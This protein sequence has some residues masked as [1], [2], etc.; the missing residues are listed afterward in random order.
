MFRHLA[1]DF[2]KVAGGKGMGNMKRTAVLAA[3]ILSITNAAVAQISDNV[4]KIGVLT[5]LSGPFSDQTGRGSV[6]GAELAA[7][8][9][10]GK[11]AGARIEIV[12]ADHQNK[13]DIGMT[14]ARRWFD[15]EQ[16]DIIVD[17]ASSVVALGVQEL[18]REKNKIAMFSGPGTVDLTGKACSPNGIHWTYD[19]YAT[20]SATATAMMDQGLDTWFFISLDTAFGRS[21]EAVATEVIKARGGKVVGTVRHPTNTYDYSS[22]LL[23]AQASGAKVVALANSGTDFVQAVKQAREFGLTSSGQKLAAMAVTLSDIKALGLETAQGMLHT[24]AFYWDFSDETRAF[25]KRFMARKD[26]VAPSQAQ[27]GTYS[28]VL[29]YLRAVQATGTDDTA[30]VLAHMKANTISDGFTPKGRIRVD[31]RMVHDMY[32]VRSKAPG[33]PKGAWDLYTVEKVIP[34]EQA[35]R[36]LDKGGCPLVSQ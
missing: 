14:T 22:F 2:E 34:G 17:L 20:A 5:D 36:P 31:G 24:E 30:K 13:A 7:E 32:L 35:F 3:A 6:I 15:V 12:S 1:H 21:A 25:A 23:Q 19:T 4:V 16:V 33:E 28:A 26:G 27:A 11:V 18:V 10:N 9:F 8:D 29:H